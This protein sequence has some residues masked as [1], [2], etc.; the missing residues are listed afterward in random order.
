MYKKY[1]SL[2]VDK[3]AQL[4]P[5]L[6]DFGKTTHGILRTP[7][8]GPTDAE[9]NAIEKEEQVAPNAN[10][11]TMVDQSRDIFVLQFFDGAK[12]IPFKTTTNID[13][14]KTYR[15]KVTDPKNWKVVK[16]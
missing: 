15:Q 11:E 12:W 9:L 8:D 2:K 3:K 1:F 16:S 10:L 6:K 7:T 5:A 14:I 13:S 4:E